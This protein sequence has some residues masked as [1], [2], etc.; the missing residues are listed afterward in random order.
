MKEIIDFHIHP[1]Y[2]KSRNVC[3]Y[4]DTVKDIEQFTEDLKRAGITKA[5]GSVIERMEPKSFNDIK[6]LND[7]ALLIRDKLNGFYIPGVHIHPAFVTESIA[8]LERAKKAGVKLV[9]ELV[10]YF[11]GW[12]DYYDKNMA[13]IYSVINELD[14]VVS[15]H[16]QREETVEEAVK[17]FPN[18]TFVAAHPGDKASLLRHIERIKKYD[19]YYL[20]L[21]GTGIFRYGLIGYGVSQ[22]GSERFLFGTD[23]PICNPLMYINAVLYEKLNSCDYDNIFSENARRILNLE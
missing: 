12:E 9:G 4:P 2:N 15:L 7:E 1:F 6:A 11:M 22:V 23:Y 5:C 19:N 3:F 14:M 8:E 21:S 16:T 17:Q 20:D 10:P 18:I 13:E